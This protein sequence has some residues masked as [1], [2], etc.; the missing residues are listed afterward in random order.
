MRMKAALASALAYRPPLLILDEPFAGLDPLVQDELIEGVLPAA[1]HA[2]T[3]IS[4]HDLAEIESFISHVGYLDEGRLRF[5]EEMASLSN[6]F[7][8][9]EIVTGDPRPPSLP[10]PWLNFERSDNCARWVDS[11]YSEE[12]SVAEIRRLFGD[13]RQITPRPMPLRSIFVTLAKASRKEV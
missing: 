5:S 10:A 2:T 6:R 11:Q 7:R 12:G 1:E 13:V 8:E 3:L 9:I 4:S